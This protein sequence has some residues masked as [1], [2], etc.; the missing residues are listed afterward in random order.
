MFFERKNISATLASSVVTIFVA[1]LLDNTSS[2]IYTI[3]I[4]KYQKYSNNK[5]TYRDTQG[6]KYDCDEIFVGLESLSFQHDIHFIEIIIII[7]NR[8]QYM[9]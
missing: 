2:V 8:L 4:N 3:V 9:R 1:K 6:H 7:I 5:T